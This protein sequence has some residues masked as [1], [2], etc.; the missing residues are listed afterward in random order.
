MTV[1]KKVYGLA[2]V[3]SLLLSAMGGLLFVEMA[4]ANPIGPGMLQQYPVITV[5]RDGSVTPQTDLISQ[6]G[7]TYTLTGNVT[8]YGIAIE[9]SDIVFDGDGYTIYLRYGMN[10]A[11]LVDTVRNV[12]IKDVEV[13]SSDTIWLNNCSYCQITGVK[14]EGEYIQLR[15]GSNYNNISQCNGPIQLGAGSQ[16]N[17]VFRNNITFLSISS[18]AESNVIYENNFL[19]ENYIPHLAAGCFWD[20]GSV[21]NYWI[22]YNGTD[23]NYNGI[24]DAPYVLND[25][26]TD[27]FPLMYPYDIENDTLILP[28]REPAQETFPTTF[29]VGASGA[30]AVV[31]AVCLLAYFKKHKQLPKNA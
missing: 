19:R 20:N 16:H 4:T 11:L 13:L 6:N 30:S 21:G 27:H 29:A 17:Q 5:N 26:N 24:G 18:N 8:D 15:D 2:F 28:I 9:C 25:V 3:L 31:V 1:T 23:A 7:T 10:P 12:T 14:A 22:D